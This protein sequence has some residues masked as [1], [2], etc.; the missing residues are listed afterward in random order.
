MAANTHYL[1][2]AKYRRTIWYSWSDFII[3]LIVVL[4]VAE[5]IVAVIYGFS[6]LLKSVF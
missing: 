3:K 4:S 6:A 2:P 1:N 5:V